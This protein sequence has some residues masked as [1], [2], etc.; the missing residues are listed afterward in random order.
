MTQFTFMSHKVTQKRRN[1]E[2]LEKPVVD[3][4]ISPAV[5]GYWFLL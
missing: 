2:K 4:G 3:I 5:I 1:Y